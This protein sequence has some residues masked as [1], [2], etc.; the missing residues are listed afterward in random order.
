MVD[1]L[2]L[3]PA[4]HPGGVAL[5]GALPAVYDTTTFAV[6]KGVHVHARS[7]PKSPGG[8]GHKD[9]D[10]SFPVVRVHAKERIVEITEDASVAYVRA[11]I[12]GVP[13]KYL[14]CPSCNHVHLDEGEHAIYP[15]SKHVCLSCGGAFEDN[16]PAVGNPIV[17][18]KDLLNDSTTA[19]LRIM[20]PKPFTI[21]Q[22]EPRLNGGIRLWGTHPAILWTAARDEEDGVHVHGFKKGREKVAPDETYGRVIV[23]GIELDPRAVRAFM[24]LRESESLRD[25]L[26]LVRCEACGR[27]LVEDKAPQAITPSTEHACECGQVVH[28]AEAVIANEM[29]SIVSRLYENAKFVGLKEN[30]T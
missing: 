17:L 14:V 13:L 15:H 12:L 16:E 3:K 25:K 26:R 19:R 18:A 23:D 6:E 7:A 4:E 28:T 20:K 11:A 1:V 9:I 22:C 8:K 21:D 30:G 24:V 10:T 5:W 27:V 29:P 2:D